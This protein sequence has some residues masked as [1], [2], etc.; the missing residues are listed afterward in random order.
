MKKVKVEEAVGKLF[1]H[2]LTKIVPGEFKGARFKKGEIIKEEDIKELKSMG[3]NHVFILDM[4]EDEYH[5][6]DAALRIAKASRGEGIRLE[7]PKEGKMTLVAEKKGLLKIDLEQLYKV[8][9]LDQLMYATIHQN[10]VVEEGKALAGTRIIPLTIKK[11]PIDTVENLLL[12]EQSQ[13][14]PMIYVKELIPYKIGIVVTGT[15]VFEG[16]IQDRFGPVL[17]KKAEEYGGVFHKMVY[18]KDEEEDI[19]EKIEELIRDGAEMIMTS[20]GMSVDADDVTPLAIKNTA[21]QVVTYGS[22]VLPGAMFMLAYKGEIP[23]L[24]IPACG[25]YHRITILDL[26]LPRVMAKETITKKD[27]NQL[28]H[29]GLCQNCAVCHYPICPLGKA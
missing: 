27:I 29:G 19:K 6:N 14:N 25:M 11:A 20:G 28:A 4:K 10:T 26:V 7:G 9:D 18:A 8:N 24:G 3:K 16:R 23:I 1:A 17:E 13:N 2:D 15:E 5:E 21:D 22:S 12:R